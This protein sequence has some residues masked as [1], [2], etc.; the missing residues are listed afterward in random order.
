MLNKFSIKIRI[1]ALT[2]VLLIISILIAGIAFRGF[3]NLRHETGN[4]IELERLSQ[5][6]QKMD[7]GHLV[8]IEKVVEYFFDPSVNTIRVADNDQSCSLGL[9]LFGE[10]GNS[11]REQY[12]Q[13]GPSLDSLTESH[14]VLHAAIYKLKKL[15][16]RANGNKLSTLPETIKVYTDQIK[17]ALNVTRQDLQTVISSLAEITQASEA[18]LLNHIISARNGISILAVIAI[19]VGLSFAVIIAVSIIKPLNTAIVLAKHMADGDFAN[20]IAVQGNDEPATLVRAL[21]QTM[22][23]V[24]SILH[25]VESEAM[26]LGNSSKEL[27]GV[28]RT[29]DTGIQATITRSES[30]AAASEEMSF[31]MN[32][33]AAASEEASTNVNLVATAAETVQSAMDKVAGQAREAREISENSV[34]MVATSS[35]KV[36]V[37]GRAAEEITKVTEVITEISEQTNLLA[38]NATIEAARAGEAGKGFAVVANEI[39]DLA[40]QTAEATSE[41]KEK[42]EAIRSSVDDTVEQIGQISGAIQQVDTV[43][44]NIASAVEEQTAST[45]EIA[46]NILQA[47][48]GIDEVNENV[49]NISTV[50]GDIAENI[51]QVNAVTQNLVASSSDVKG[52]SVDLHSCA[53]RFKEGMERFE[54]ASG[55]DIAAAFSGDL[56][57]LVIWDERIIL[58]IP[59]I[60][61]QHKVLAELINKIYWIIK[62]G[63]DVEHMAPLIEELADYTEKH[64]SFEEGLLIK[65]KYPGFAAHKKI[66]VSVMNTVEKYKNQLK[67]GTLVVEELMSFVSDWLVRHIK[68]EDRNYLPAVKKIM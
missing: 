59:A 23:H 39:K 41:I 58:G 32:A 55:A 56:T 44:I 45:A 43:V 49:A 46:G 38:L 62:Q 67:N 64:F 28:S 50:S 35:E 16:E 5:D 68:K 52:W 29:L 14:K 11:V 53:T 15:Y 61:E 31:N 19:L 18:K 10:G 40:K 3:R 47:A 25:N 4:A 12:P 63:Y 6:L 24:S 48:A 9:W 8:N 34:V 36:D 57:D 17:P 20:R 7:V 1:I 42:I 26:V 60:D 54:L 21:N 37:L 33:V 65:A 27:G 51:S 30:V 2:A 13:V 22:V 66:H